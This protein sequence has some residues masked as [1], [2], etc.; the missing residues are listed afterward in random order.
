[1]TFAI[2]IVAFVAIWAIIGIWSAGKH[3]TLDD[4]SDDDIYPPNHPGST[5]Y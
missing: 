2:F 3:D 1:M 4:G 5:I